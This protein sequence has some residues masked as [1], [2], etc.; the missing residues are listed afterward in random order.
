MDV[1]APGRVPRLDLHPEHLDG[2]EIPKPPSAWTHT[3]REGLSTKEKRAGHNKQKQESA[4][5]FLFA[6]NGPGGKKIAWNRLQR[7]PFG[8]EVRAHS[9]SLWLITI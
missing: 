5:G 4:H 9:S 1:L 6:A 7:G 2:Q 8:F 3:W